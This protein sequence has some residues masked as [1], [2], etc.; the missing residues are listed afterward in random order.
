MYL[1]APKLVDAKAV[2]K[3]LR[4]PA[5]WIAAEA[6][7]GRIPCLQAGT[8]QLFDLESVEAALLLR[9]KGQKNEHPKNE[10]SD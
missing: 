7:A 2:G 4:V 1:A 6:D 9:A 3:W 8:V 10:T 5:S